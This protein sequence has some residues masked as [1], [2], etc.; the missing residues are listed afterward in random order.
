MLN[1]WLPRSWVLGTKAVW[2]T[3]D[4]VQLIAII[5]FHHTS[6]VCCVRFAQFFTAPLFTPSA[7][8]REVNAVNSENDKNLQNDTWRMHQLEKSTCKPGHDYTKFGTGMT[9][10]CWLSA[11]FAVLHRRFFVFTVIT[12]HWDRNKVVLRSL[13]HCPYLWMNLDLIS[14]SYMAEV[15]VLRNY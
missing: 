13:S 7:V 3:I 5:F 8:E 1:F 6:L 9:L 2:L 12:F 14:I 11:S 15:S 4:Y 10:R